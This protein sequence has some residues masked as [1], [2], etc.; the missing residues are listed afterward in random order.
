MYEGD[1]RNALL[2]R[3]VLEK[4]ND[5]TVR[6]HQKEQ[7]LRRRAYECCIINTLVMRL[8]YLKAPSTCM[9]SGLPNLDLCRGKNR[10]A[11]AASKIVHCQR[12]KP[13]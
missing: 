9:T 6:E 8:L 5:E 13:A 10:F 7:T 11:H 1:A 2:T 3:R 12:S 4:L